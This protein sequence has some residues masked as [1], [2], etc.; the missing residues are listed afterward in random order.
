MSKVGLDAQATEPLRDLRAAAVDQHRIDAEALEPDHIVE[1]RALFAHRA[2]D[3]HH[4]RLADELA[5]VRERFQE[6]V[7][8]LIDRDLRE[9][10]VEYALFSTT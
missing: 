5:D 10:Y 1:D 2:T 9:H 3:L 7:R 4:D 8:F 6:R